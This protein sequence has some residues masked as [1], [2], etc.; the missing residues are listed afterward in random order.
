MGSDYEKSLTFLE[1][2]CAKFQELRIE[3][4]L[5]TSIYFI[6]KT[7]HNITKISEMY[8]DHLTTWSPPPLVDRSLY[9]YL[10]HED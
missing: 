5:T 1:K 6:L 10:N 4:A 2:Q 3:I 9:E 8:S 7:I